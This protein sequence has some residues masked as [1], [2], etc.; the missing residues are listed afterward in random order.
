MGV[1]ADSD[2]AAGEPAGAR[3]R[4]RV[5]AIDGR[6][7]FGWVFDEARPLDRLVAEVELDGTVIASAVADRPRIDLRRNGIG[8]GSHAF[9]LDLDDAALAARDRIVVAA[10]S[11][12]SGAREVLRL[13]AAAQL[14]AEAVIAT[15]LAGILARLE[16]MIAT[17]RRLLLSQRDLVLRQSGDLAPEARDPASSPDV[18]AEA[19]T[20]AAEAQARFDQLD[21]FLLRYETALASLDER[22]TSLDERLRKPLRRALLVLS[23][24][25]VLGTATAIVAVGSLLLRR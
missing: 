23:G 16:A 4:G 6:R 10:R 11:P 13:P 9:D 21:L 18:L 5:D 20:L 25:S 7:L 2:M 1:P 17:Q 12:T 15:P 3:I 24:L 8:D 19:R 14:E 22:L